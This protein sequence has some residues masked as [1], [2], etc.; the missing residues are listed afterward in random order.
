MEPITSRSIRFAEETEN[1]NIARPME[2]SIAR[3]PLTQRARG[4][5]WDALA[6]SLQNHY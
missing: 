4:S 6:D 3:A 5:T 2:V 1:R